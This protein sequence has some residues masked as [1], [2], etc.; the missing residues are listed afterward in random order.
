MRPRRNRSVKALPFGGAFARRQ[1]EVDNL[2]L[3]VGPQP[4]RSQHRPPQGPAPVLRQQTPSS[5]NTLYWFLS[6]RRWKAATALS[7]VLATRLTVV[8]L[9]SRPS[10]ASSVSPTLQ[11]DKPRTKPARMT[12]SISASAGHRRAEPRLGCN[13]GSRHPWFDVAERGQQMA[14]VMPIAPIRSVTGLE[15]VE[16]AVDRHRHLVLDDLRQGLTAERAIAFAPL[17]A[18]VPSPSPSRAPLVD[19]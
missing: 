11:V 3:A 18:F 8:A 9:S 14:R 19:L 7:S 16:I 2:L 15:L 5:I 10:I 6:G 4:Q 17:Q 12:R 1:A 13:A